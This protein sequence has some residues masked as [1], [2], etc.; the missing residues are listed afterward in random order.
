MI[1]QEKVV[2]SGT[3]VVAGSGVGAAAQAVPFHVWPE[4]QFVGVSVEASRVAH[5]KFTP[6][7]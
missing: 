7:K 2:P 3:H 4:E 5:M 6:S 1:A